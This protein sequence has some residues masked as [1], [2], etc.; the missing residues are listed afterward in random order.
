MDKYNLD[1]DIDNLSPFDLIDTWKSVFMLCI[2]MKI[3]NWTEN[4][5]FNLGEYGARQ[6]FIFKVFIFRHF[7]SI[8]ILFSKA[9]S[10]WKNIIILVSL[11]L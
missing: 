10:F 7:V 11:K 5:I 8:D 2:M 9:P 4:D 3:F 6:S 1:I